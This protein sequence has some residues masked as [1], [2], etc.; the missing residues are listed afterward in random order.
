MY[1]L[2]ENAVRL[3]V[4]SRGLNN[5][6]K[7][8]RYLFLNV[9]NKWGILKSK[10]RNFK[11]IFKEIKF[12]AGLSSGELGSY[13]EIFVKNVYDKVPDFIAKEGETVV[14]IGSNIGLFTLK[15]A[16]RAGATGKVWSFEPNPASFER[17]KINLDEN[18]VKNV[19]AFQKA[20]TSNAGKMKF[21]V[22]PGVTPEGRLFHSGRMPGSSNAG[23]IEVECI[24]LDDFV[25]ANSIEK[26]DILKVDTEGEECEVLAGASQKALFITKKIV[27]EYHG[28]DRKEKAIDILSKIGFSVVS[29]DEKNYILYFKRDL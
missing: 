6:A 26:V 27:M 5:K 16:I 24:T 21:I 29:E 20:V 17:L 13:V 3:F 7:F 25:A 1:D 23:V 10:N 19:M 22:D 8:A 11:F 15:Q 28:K 4:S 9:L 2:I 12:W 18:R 14:D